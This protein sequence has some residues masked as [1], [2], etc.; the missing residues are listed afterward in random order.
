MKPRI[1]VA[2]ASPNIALI[3]YW[4]N[5]DDALRLP[6]NGSISMTL[7]RLETTTEVV[8]DAS[9]PN[10]ILTLNGRP[11]PPEA[12]RRIAEHLGRVRALAGLRSPARVRSRSNFPAGAGIASSASAFAA[13]TVAAASAAGLDLDGASLSRLARRGSG[14]A[15][16]SIF[17][18]FVE[19]RAGDRDEASYAEPLAP[20]D[21]W[22]LIDLVAIVSRKPKQIGS[23][24]GHALAATSP[25]Q[26]ARVHDAPQRL[27]GCR[28][29]L[30]ERDFP[31]LA[32]VVEHDS[33]LMHAVMMTSRPS[34]LYWLPETLA[35]MTAIRAWRNAGLE[36]CFTIDAGPNVHCLCTPQAAR[37][38]SRR[39]RA[40]PGVIEVI[41]CPPGEPPRM[42]PGWPG[43][44]KPR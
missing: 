8:F 31:R 15:C 13:L 28:R 1:A 36:V 33:H 18:G 38:A 30:L 6:A 23:T 4:G 43:R 29:A 2:A 34:L 3:K 42:L 12:L 44:P 19:W 24:D 16:R 21:H 11:A 26:A 5:R 27:A 37:G 35:L 40:L 20:G 17:G 10:D 9:L 14:S 32:A 22:P 41:P 39:L 25:I 7:G